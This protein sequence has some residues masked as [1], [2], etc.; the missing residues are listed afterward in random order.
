ME[1]AHRALQKIHADF[2]LDAVALEERRDSC[3]QIKMD[4]RQAI[5]RADTF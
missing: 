4:I 5:V 1:L 2:W 3:Q